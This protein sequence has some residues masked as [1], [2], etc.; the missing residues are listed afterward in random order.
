[1]DIRSAPFANR[2]ECWCLHLVRSNC[3]KSPEG[4]QTLLFVLL[5]LS[6]RRWILR[7]I[8]DAVQCGRAR[9]A[10]GKLAL[11]RRPRAPSE[12]PSVT[13]TLP[14]PLATVRRWAASYRAAETKYGNGYMGLLPRTNDRGN[15]TQRLPENTRLMMS[16][17]ITGDYETLKQKSMYISWIG[18]KRACEARNIQ[19]PSYKTFC[20]A[21]RGKAGFWQTLKRQ[22]RRAAYVQ[23]PFYIEL[24]LKTPRHGDHPRSRSGTSITPNWTWKW[25]PPT[26]VRFSDGHG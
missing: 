4:G 11:S 19:A 20:L 25:F 5:R 14:S 8:E 13:R 26:Q 1:M 6:I 18:L 22:G 3:R 7:D 10:D 23:E 17:F 15:S 9:F 12:P 24:D 21:V 16:E 2:P